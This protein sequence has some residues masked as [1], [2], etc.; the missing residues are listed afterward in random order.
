MNEQYDLFSAAPAKPS[1][2]IIVFPL[3]RREK[4][5]RATAWTLFSRKTQQGKQAFWSRTIRTLKEELRGRDCGVDEI[6]RQIAAF[7]AGI[8]VELGRLQDGGR[9]QPGGAR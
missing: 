3:A 6:D 4:T 2:A 7:R 1:A 8:E 9:Q 5:I